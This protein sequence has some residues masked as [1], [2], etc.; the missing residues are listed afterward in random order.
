MQLVQIL[1]LLAQG[2]TDAAVARQLHIGQRTVE[3]RIAALMARHGIHSRIQL[4]V[5]AARRGWIEGHPVPQV[6]MLP[7]PRPD[8]AV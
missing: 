5:L 7:L 4:G 8:G 2:L 1:G 3:R 6:E